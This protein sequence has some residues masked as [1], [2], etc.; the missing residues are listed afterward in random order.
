MSSAL[1]WD[2][3]VWLGA[4]CAPTL[5][6]TF[7]LR[8]TGRARWLVRQNLALLIVEPFVTLLLVWTNG[9]HG[10]IESTVRLN[11][12]GPFSSLVV[13][14]GLW[15]WV[16]SAYS[17]LLLFLGAFILCSFIL[18]VARFSHLF[19]ILSGETAK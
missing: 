12:S 6:L 1:W 17:Y 13:N 14:Y 5:W 3:F 8:Y 4:T 2:N 11:T 18:T 9:F 7:A 10:L 15:Y 19:S 16:N